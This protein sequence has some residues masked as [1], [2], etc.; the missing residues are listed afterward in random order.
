MREHI[1]Q[2]RSMIEHQDLGGLATLLQE[3]VYRHLGELNNPE[4]YLYA[5]S[6]TKQNRQRISGRSGA[7]I[8]DCP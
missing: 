7:R 6:G 2:M 8:T 1:Q 4:L 3:S 5:R